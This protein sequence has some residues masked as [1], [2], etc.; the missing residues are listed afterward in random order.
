MQCP[1]CGYEP[2]MSEMQR[3]PDDCVKCGV[4]YE[5]HA[6][7]MAS[8]QAQREAERSAN[9]VRA[10]MAPAVLDAH[11]KYPGAQPVVVVDIKMSF[12]SMVVFMV[13]WALASIPALIILLMI[14]TFAISFVSSFLFYSSPPRL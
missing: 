6:R 5:G 13:K 11:S 3:S 1:K 9:A 4:N 8:V 14:G 2:T 10:K 12:W 7:H